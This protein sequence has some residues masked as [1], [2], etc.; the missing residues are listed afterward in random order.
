MRYDIINEYTKAIREYDHNSRTELRKLETI[1]QDVKDELDTHPID[2]KVL[3]EIKKQM[4][5]FID[6]NKDFIN[7]EKTRQIYTSGNSLQ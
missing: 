7:S 4:Q 1:T 5:D 3:A 6:C 2:P